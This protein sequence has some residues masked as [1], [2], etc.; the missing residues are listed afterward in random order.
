M[1]MCLKDCG[2]VKRRSR[3]VGGEDTEINEYPWQVGMVQINSTK[4]YCGASLINEEW[5]L[6]ANHC[7]PRGL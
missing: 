7:F 5:V 4:P 6:T 1:F 2:K 3:I